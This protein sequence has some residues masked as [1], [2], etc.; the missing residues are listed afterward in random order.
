MNAAGITSCATAPGG[1]SSHNRTNM[2]HIQSA[3]WGASAARVAAEAVA[4]PQRQRVEAR[5]AVLEEQ[6]AAAR[7]AAAP[8]LGQRRAAAEFQGHRLRL[9]AAGDALSQ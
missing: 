6:H 4:L 1:G 9:L 7:L 3:L 8:H 2:T 5:D